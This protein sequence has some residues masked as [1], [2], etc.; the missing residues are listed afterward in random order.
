MMD[1]LRAAANHVVLK[2][3]LA[4]II[5]SFV[6]TGMTGYLAGGNRDYAAKV[7]GQKISRQA[8]ES[9][10]LAERNR[11]QQTLGEQFSE[12]AGN[13]SALKQVRVSALNQLINEMLVEQYAAKNGISISDAQVKAAILAEPVF[14][15]NGKFDNTRFNGLLRQ[16]GVTPEQYAESMR[17]TLI[18]RQVTQGVKDTE[19]YL[20][21]EQD[22]ML[23]MLAQSR[24]V[25]QAKLDVKQLA[26]DQQVSDS[27][28]TT[29]YQQHKPQYRSPEQ[30]RVRYIRL[31][32]E[33]FKAQQTASEEEIARYYTTHRAEFTRQARQRFRIIQS[34]TR[35]QAEA[36]LVALKQGADFSQLAKEKSTDIVSA[37][38]GGDTGWMAVSVIPQPLKEAGLSQKDQLSGVIDAGSAFLVAQLTDSQPESVQPL[39]AVHDAIADKVKWEKA[40]DAFYALQQKASDAANSDNE[41]LAEVEKVTGQQAQLTDWFDRDHVPQALDF[42]PLLEAIYR[43][44][45]IGADGAPGSNSDVITVN[46]RLAYL[47]RIEGHKAETTKAL[48]TVRDQ[49]VEAIRQHKARQQATQRAEKIVAALNKGDEAAV[50]KAEGLTFGEPH[51]ITRAQRDPVAQTVFALPLPTNKPV[52][53]VS[54]DEAGDVILLA[55][56]KTD[57]AKLDESDATIKQQLSRS[58]ADLMFTTFVQSLR[59]QAKITLGSGAEL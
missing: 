34:K 25:R 54:N 1:S 6:V 10:Y 5:L 39:S 55:F 8:L 20:P 33:A 51:A 37:R 26:R 49:V 48:E 31:D 47:I 7:N 19:F 16:A 43:G 4:A 40:Q 36:I 24:L 3:I 27:E 35:Q 45:L 17:E 28:I 23:V 11:L 13:E 42:K 30:Y 57:K 32:A 58:W 2:I 9:R 41:S 12:L 22:G 59:E 29:W 56:D 38:Q 52:Y 18:I 14:Q 44:D 53:G 50:M 46:D 15:V 21:Q